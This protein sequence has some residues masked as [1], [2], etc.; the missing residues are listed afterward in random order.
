MG[1]QQ[2]DAT[3]SRGIDKDKSYIFRRFNPDCHI[4]DI[5]EPYEDPPVLAPRQWRKEALNIIHRLSHDVI[6]A[7]LVAPILNDMASVITS[8]F[9]ITYAAIETFENE[10]LSF[11][12]T[13]IHEGSTSDI[14]SPIAIVPSPESAELSLTLAGEVIRHGS[15][16]VMSD[17]HKNEYVIC[18]SLPHKNHVYHYI[19]VP[20]VI[21]SQINGVLSIATSH[22]IIVDS[23]TLTWAETMAHHISALLTREAITSRLKSQE[24]MATN[25]LNAL[26]SPTV[27]CSADGVILNINSAF[28]LMVEEFHERSIDTHTTNIFQLFDNTHQS[29]SYVHEFRGHLHNLFG[30]R[31]HHSRLDLLLSRPGFH[32]WYLAT[33]SLMPDHETAIIM[34]VDIS[35]RK[36]AE[37][38]LEHEMLHDQ[39]TG[40]ANRI[41]FHDRVNSAHAY[42]SAH[43][44]STCIIALDI[45]RYAFIVE[46]LGH[47]AADEI[48]T[49]VAKRIE[50]ISHPSDVI[51]RIGSSEFAILVEHIHNA[52]EARDFSLNIIDMFRLPFDIDGQ[53]MLLQPSIGITV[54]ESHSS[55]DAD[56]MLHDAHAAMTQARDNS[57]IQYAF[58]SVSRSSQAY[59]KLK[60]ERELIH[61]IEENQLQVY[62]QPECELLT[63]SI[64]GV[65]ALVRWVHPKHGI[66]TPDH[67]VGLAEESGL[68]D[69]LFEK[70]F[71]TAID[72]LETIY[73]RGHKITV[74]TNL[75][76]KQ[77]TNDATAKLIAMYLAKA[78]IPAHMVGLEITETAVMENSEVAFEMLSHL[79]SL[80]VSLSLDDFGTGYSSLAYLQRFPVD[81][82]KID[83]TFISELGTAKSSTEI[84][85]AVIG[86]AHGLRLHALA[87]G[88]ETP[89]Q[90]AML[91]E[92]GCD[93]AQGY[94]FSH[95]LTFEKLLDFLD[96]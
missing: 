67:F 87:E 69:A 65:E 5:S 29:N 85:S 11:S 16:L 90:V 55:V 76:A 84:V 20:L 9:P 82:I 71:S 24:N 34:F 38:Q 66:L 46:S 52:D 56:M 12:A 3:G 28:R 2:D 63:G 35:D 75:S 8:A 89:S 59:K 95:P 79:K 27:M 86:L 88:V 30:N 6:D 31:I 19:G 4:S 25:M 18:P 44:T 37:E 60:R 77:I 14:G 15:T 26:S 68:I 49:K 54:S 93:R 64:I 70:V 36:R 72:D 83:R 45:G 21:D 51:A 48:I 41:L 1:T 57:V 80:G 23:E 74:W 53:E 40:L 92:L 96:K 33:M 58:S 42:N 22:N 32:R 10:S 81:M 62:Y 43:N 78:S 73:S 17:T 50:S 94:F 7:T 91:R 47:S 39:A 61:A 13:S